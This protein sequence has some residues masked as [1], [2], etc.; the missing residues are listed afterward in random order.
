[1]LGR[2]YSVR[3]YIVEGDRRGRTLGFPTANLEP[4]N[5]ILPAAGVYAG[6]MRFLDEGD[7]KQGVELAAVTNLGIRPTFTADGA[8]N[9]NQM[10][11][12]AHLLDFEGD[13][14]GRRVEL[15]FDGHLRPEKRFS[16][17]D[18]LREQIAADVD[19]AR[20][21]LEVSGATTTVRDRARPVRNAGVCFATPAFGSAC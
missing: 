3:G 19:E 8:E 2:P 11:T 16:G 17:P 10:H 20:R 15:S 1:M 6:R 7:P 14:Y 4:D 13:V 5:E 18:A 21:L 9:A 12:E